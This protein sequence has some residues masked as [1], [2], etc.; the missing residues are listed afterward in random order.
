M[1]KF[2]YYFVCNYLQRIAVRCTGKGCDFYICIWGHLK[3]DEMIVKDFK[4]DYIHTASEQCYMRRQGRRMMRVKL[5]SC[6]IDGK[7]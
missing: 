2:D 1:N 7:V 3:M 6:F 4:R 5:L